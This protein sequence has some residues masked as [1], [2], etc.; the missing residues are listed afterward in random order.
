MHNRRKPCIVDVQRHQLV[1]TVGSVV[2]FKSDDLRS[3]PFF[4]FFFKGG[5]A[6]KLEFFKVFGG[7]IHRSSHPNLNDFRVPICS[8]E[9]S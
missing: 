4:V 8:P 9:T 1:Q 5:Q 6:K 7:E 2:F 3:F